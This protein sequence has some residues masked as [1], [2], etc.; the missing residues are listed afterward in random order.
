MASSDPLVS[1]GWRRRWLPLLVAVPIAAA[2]MFWFGLGPFRRAGDNSKVA[3]ELTRFDSKNSLSS[4]SNISSSVHARFACRRLLLLS[5]FD[6]PLI[7]RVGIELAAALRKLPGVKQVEGAQLGGST[8]PAPLGPDIVLT[9]RLEQLAESGVLSKELDAQVVVTAGA[10]PA[11]DNLSV[12]NHLT[13]PIVE[14]FWRGQLD[15]HSTTVGLQSADGRYRR[16]AQDIAGE[17]AKSLLKQFGEWRDKYGKLPELPGE[18]YPAFRPP[19][20]LPLE[21]YR[22]RLLFA[23]AGF[24]KPC[25]ATWECRSDK[26]LAEAFAELESR[27]DKSRWKGAATNDDNQPRLRLKDDRGS[28]AMFPIN[29]SEIRTIPLPAVFYVRYVERMNEHERSAAMDELFAG[30]PQLDTL[31]MFD[32]AM[33]DPQRQRLLALLEEH[34]PTTAAGWLSFSEMLKLTKQDARAAGCVAIRDSALAFRRGRSGR[35]AGPHPGCRQESWRRE[36]GRR[37]TGR[38]ARRCRATQEAGLH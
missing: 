21:G 19:P 36:T 33:D 24:M 17:F 10:A 8:A 4:A 32:H 26:P 9:V 34:P 12:V 6:E 14:F 28:L 15:H 38:R 13:P 16:V 20:Q 2:I 7:E 11:A 30:R 22:P 35:V 37:E 27:F 31:L 18:F 5:E 25:D 23:D 29:A 3:A 1:P